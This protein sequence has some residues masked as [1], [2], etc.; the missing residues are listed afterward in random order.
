MCTQAKNSNMS[1]IIS[2]E[3]DNSFHK[4]N[5]EN[6]IVETP[7]HIIPIANRGQWLGIKYKYKN[8]TDKLKVQTPE[9]FSFGISQYDDKSSAPKMSFVMKNRTL[10]E[11]NKETLSQD[12]LIDIKVE[13]ESIKI[14]EDITTKIKQEMNTPTMVA[15]FGKKNPKKWTDDVNE[16]KIITHSQKNDAIYINP[17][18]V[19]AN[20]FMKTKFILIDDSHEEGYQDLDQEEA[21]TK[22]S[23]VGV[24]CT[25]TAMITVDSVYI[26]LK[27]SI[28]VKLT[29]VMI[30]EYHESNKKRNIIIPARLRNKSY[31]K[32]VI[33]NESDSDSD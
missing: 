4:L 1:N 22:L 21:I 19:T 7:S 23:T 16:M 14:F 27:P 8:K 6:I 13:N 17:K 12:D 3:E 33:V 31:E 11:A 30:R 2:A 20:N 25:A 10:H 26:G 28:Q 5:T 32:K 29:E 9:Y 18:V 24:N 15:L